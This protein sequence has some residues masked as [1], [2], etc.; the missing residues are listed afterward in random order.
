[1]RLHQREEREVRGRRVAQQRVLHVERAVGLPRIAV[2]EDV[3]R[4][5]D[6]AEERDREKDDEVVDRDGDEGDEVLAD[7]LQCHPEAQRGT[8]G[9]GR[10]DA[11]VTRPPGPS[12]RS[13]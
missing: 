12:L 11:S 1:M 13:G 5:D 6:A 4:R 7:S 2:V 10:Y 9:Y 8:W 3:V